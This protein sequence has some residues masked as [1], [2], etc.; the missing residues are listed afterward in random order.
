MAS[1]CHTIT[2]T[3]TTLSPLPSL[4]AP[5][6]LFIPNANT[7]FQQMP[8]RIS[9]TPENHPPSVRKRAVF[10]PP[11]VEHL[12][13]PNNIKEESLSRDAANWAV[14]SRRISK[15]DAF[16][17]YRIKENHL[18][19]FIKGK[20]DDFRHALA[21]ETI[22]NEAIK[23]KDNDIFSHIVNNIRAVK[24]SNLCMC[25]EIDNLR[26]LATLIESRKVSTCKMRSTSRTEQT[27]RIHAYLVKNARYDLVEA[28]FDMEMYPNSI[29]TMHLLD[30]QTIP[31]SKILRSLDTLEICQ[32]VIIT[33]LSS[34]A[35]GHILFL[36]ELIEQTV[37]IA[38]KIKKS[39][40]QPII[41]Y[42]FLHRLISNGY[43]GIA[44]YFYITFRAIPNSATVNEI[45][46]I[47]HQMNNPGIDGECGIFYKPPIT[48]HIPFTI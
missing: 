35:R 28:L 42:T 13:Y 4:M 40:Q 33:I 16:L 7:S 18:I 46:F 19:Q 15:V 23:E 22:L 8:P 21:E 39:P 1:Y 37:A 9:H 45:S 5:R 29:I 6:P 32:A 20:E 38:R 24:M 17:Y 34:K 25:I 11:Q 30:S 31:E 3:M 14:K 44:Y 12:C 10:V 27:S 2:T 43:Y 41:S 48:Q 26:Y 36:D 47:M